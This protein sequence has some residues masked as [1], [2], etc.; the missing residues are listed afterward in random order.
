M[1]SN[2]GLIRAGKFFTREN[3]FTEGNRDWFGGNNIPSNARDVIFPK[4]VEI[5][6]GKVIF[7]GKK[8]SSQ[9]NPRFKYIGNFIAYSTI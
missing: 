5:T 6:R 4:P 9:F 2:R 7:P 8:L 1:H 3:H